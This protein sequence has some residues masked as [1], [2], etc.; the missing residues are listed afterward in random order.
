MPASSTGFSSVKLPA[1]L[2]QRA[3]E[4]AQAAIQESEAAAKQAREKAPDSLVAL[5]TRVLAASTNGVLQAD[6]GTLVEENRQQAVQR[7][8]A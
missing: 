7:T 2:V 4:A 6:I 8:A 5:K 3:R 1:A